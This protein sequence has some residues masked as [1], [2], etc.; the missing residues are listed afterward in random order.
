MTQPIGQ[1]APS[2]GFCGD[3]NY[4]AKMFNFI[5]VLKNGSKITVDRPFDREA[6]LESA[7]ALNSPAGTVVAIECGRERLDGPNLAKALYG[8]A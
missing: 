3:T 7:R 8:S 5:I 1:I 4:E 2:M 6:A